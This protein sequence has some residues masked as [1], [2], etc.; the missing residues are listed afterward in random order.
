MTEK[1]IK[2]VA[3]IIVNLHGEKSREER[4]NEL[5]VE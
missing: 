1:E 3:V 2:L 4:S 5:M